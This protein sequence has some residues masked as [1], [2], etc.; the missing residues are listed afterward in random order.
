MLN[1]AVYDRRIEKLERLA[2][3]HRAWGL[4]DAAL[5]F[6]ERCA[7]IQKYAANQGLILRW[8]AGGSWHLGWV[9]PAYSHINTYSTPA[10]NERKLS[11]WRL[12]RKVDQHIDAVFNRASKQRNREMT[13]KSREYWTPDKAR[14][15]WDKK[16]RTMTRS[17]NNKP[18]TLVRLYEEEKQTMSTTKWQQDRAGNEDC[19]RAVEQAH[20]FAVGDCV[21]DGQITGTIV[22]VWTD[23]DVS[24]RSPFDG[25]LLIRL[26]EDLTEA[27]STYCEHDQQTDEHLPFADIEPTSQAQQFAVGDRVV[28]P[29]SKIPGTITDIRPVEYTV[30]LDNGAE[31]DYRAEQLSLTPD[32]LSGEEAWLEVAL[33][34]GREVT[35][36]STVYA[37]WDNNEGG[38]WQADKTQI[39]HQAY[40]ILGGN[41]IPVGRTG[42]DE[43]EA[44]K[45]RVNG[46]IERAEKSV[47]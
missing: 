36:R 45:A 38:M 40:V 22:Q 42:T 14:E 6:N 8:D 24:I 21:T 34:V 10:Y 19:G 7:R 30:K 4:H 41:N 5:Y 12:A 20:Q 15:E 13:S 1:T 3:K 46:L 43:H 39:R 33:M 28:T 26:A 27:Y 32:K 9:D 23:G 18:Y 2:G 35:E 31:L 47:A 25:K 44:I 16:E 29:W 37:K 17:A 11:S